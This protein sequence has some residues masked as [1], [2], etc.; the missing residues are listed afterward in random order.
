MHV[1]SSGELN[2]LATELEILSTIFKRR[3]PEKA[4]RKFAPPR[5]IPFLPAWV[6]IFQMSQWGDEG[7]KANVSHFPIQGSDC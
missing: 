5:I 2:T 7:K 1:F 6:K 4:E 3:N